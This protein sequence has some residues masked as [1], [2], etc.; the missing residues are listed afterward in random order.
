MI[1]DVAENPLN[2]RD[3]DADQAEIDELKASLAADGQ[4]H[5][6]A[7]VSRQGFLA[8]FPEYEATVGDAVYVQVTGG[9]RRRALLQLHRSRIEI[10]IRENVASSRLGFLTATL[11]EN[12]HRQDL[13][14]IEEARAL[15]LIVAEVGGVQSEVARSMGKSES[16]VSQR[17][18]LLKLIPELQRLLRDREMSFRIA[19][20]VSAVPAD[21]QMLK[22][23]QLKTEPDQTTEA[24]GDAPGTVKPSSPRAARPSPKATAVRRLGTT[25]PQIGQTLMEHIGRDRA[26]E[27][28]RWLLAQAGDP[29]TATG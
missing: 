17:L 13:D 1:S 15:E 6:C 9:R 22:W 14:L 21:Q 10:S 23:E 8:I 19:R 5:S 16:W 26:V 11:K 28:A 29:G 2:T 12:T 20:A 7:V 27:L 4:L 3:L 18:G 25:A 24:G